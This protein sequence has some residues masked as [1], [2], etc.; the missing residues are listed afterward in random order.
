VTLMRPWATVCPDLGGEVGRVAGD[1]VER[2]QLGPGGRLQMRGGSL[3][4][5]LYRLRRGLLRLLL[6]LLGKCRCSQR[7]SRDG[8]KGQSG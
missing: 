3:L 2:A 8:S 7:A 6:R 5:L 4:L 1:L